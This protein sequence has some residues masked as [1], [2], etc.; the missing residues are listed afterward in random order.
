MKIVYAPKGENPRTFQME[1]V[2][3]L[4]GPECELIED[5]GGSQW[6][7]FGG[8]FD[9]LS[10]DGYR[11]TKALVWVL[12][13]RLNPDLGFE[14]LI[15]FK[16]ADVSISDDEVEEGKGESDEAV[17]VPVDEP[18]SSASPTPDSEA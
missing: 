12:L 14:E 8:W 10:R 5:A 15:R 16:M 13:R 9:L 3:D 6:D 1:A 11:A 2:D 17:S 4:E 7:T 18:T